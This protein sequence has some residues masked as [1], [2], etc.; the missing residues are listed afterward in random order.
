VGVT[1]RTVR[2]QNPSTNV[3]FELTPLDGRKSGP[4]A[5][6]DFNLAAMRDSQRVNERR[7]ACQSKQGLWEI[8]GTVTAAR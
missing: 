3:R 5:C 8:V 4:G 2:W 1:G 6:R 7:T